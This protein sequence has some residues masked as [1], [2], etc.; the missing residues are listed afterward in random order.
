MQ[1][2]LDSLCEILIGLPMQEA[3]DHAII[4]TELAVRDIRQPHP[5]TGIILPKNADPLFRVPSQLVNRLFEDYITSTGYRPIANFFDPGPKAAWK[6]MSPE[7]R[8][9]QISDVIVAHGPTVGLHNGEVHVVECKFP[10]AVTIL[11]NDELPIPEKRKIALKLE[12]L[13]REKC[14]PRLEVFC[15]EKK[16][17]SKLRRQIEKANV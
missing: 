7:E 2:A 9:K 8:E 15:E 16:D 11:F 10:Y 17:L 6:A 3:R 1:A 13:V 12:R 14:D 5:I 4:R